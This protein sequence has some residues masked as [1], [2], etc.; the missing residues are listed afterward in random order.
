MTM[1][2]VYD[3]ILYLVPD[4]KFMVWDCPRE[5]YQGESVPVEVSGYLI[6]WNP[7]NSVSCPTPKQIL[8]LDV[9]V[10]AENAAVREKQWRDDAAKDDPNVIMNYTVAKM[11]NPDVSLTTFLDNVEA[12]Q[13][14]QKAVTVNNTI[15]T[16]QIN[17]SN[18]TTK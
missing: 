14:S 18:Q 4:A 8:G 10:V 15:Q 11:V 12:E 7:V 5:K 17:Q 3:A 1:K 9:T 2:E 16:N 6:D 13:T